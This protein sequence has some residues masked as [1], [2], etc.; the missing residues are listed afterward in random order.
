M[1]CNMLYSAYIGNYDLYSCSYLDDLDRIF[2]PDYCPTMQDVLR[3]RIP[4]TG[5]NEYLFLIKDILFRLMCM[6]ELFV[7]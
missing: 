4:T 2:L 6:I 5:I 7:S 3:T 1:K